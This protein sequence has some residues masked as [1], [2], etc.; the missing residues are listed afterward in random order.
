M[1]SLSN[2]IAAILMEMLDEHGRAEIKRNEFAQQIG[3]VPSQINY[4][5]SSRFTPEQGFVVE[6]RRGGGGYIK[7]TRVNYTD[8]SML[9]HIVNSIGSAIDEQTAK[10]NIVNL[11]HSGLIST[12]QAQMMLA[13]VNENGYR[14]I[15][16]G[17][18]GSVRA[19][20]LKQ[21]L[22]ACL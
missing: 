4:V 14:M 9:M 6:S 20:V 3:C 16:M 19:A 2:E 17:I 7:I 5:L 13:A 11:H 10:A 15:D 12:S 18:R 21:M 22:L 8:E 1:L